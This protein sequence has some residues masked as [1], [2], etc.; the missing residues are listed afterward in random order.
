MRTKPQMRHPLLGANAPPEA[1][2]AAAGCTAYGLPKFDHLGGLIN[3][4]GNQPSSLVQLS[5]HR[6][7]P[8]VSSAAC[9]A[10][11]TAFENAQFVSQRCCI[12]TAAWR[13][14]D[15]GLSEWI[16]EAARGQK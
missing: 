4:D 5:C 8:V 6:H 9:E 7:V 12:S 2:K 16:G 11:P 13:D 10:G 14:I 1:Q 15:E 3:L